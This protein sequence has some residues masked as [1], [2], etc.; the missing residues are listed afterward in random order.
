MRRLVCCAQVTEDGP[1]LHGRPRTASLT[2]ALQRMTFRRRP[3]SPTQADIPPQ[4]SQASVSALGSAAAPSVPE[5]DA[6]RDGNGAHPAARQRRRRK[7][8]R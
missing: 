4:P 7:A 3:K 5:P 8:G 2:G 6:G 1:G